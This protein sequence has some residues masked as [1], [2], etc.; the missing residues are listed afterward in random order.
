MLFFEA[1]IEG[2]K[3]ILQNMDQSGDSGDK[4]SN[5]KE[6]E[7]VSRLNSMLPVRGDNGYSLMISGIDQDNL[8]GIV[9]ISDIRKPVREV[10]EALQTFLQSKSSQTVRV[11]LEEITADRYSKLL[12]EGYEDDMISRNMKKQDREMR[13]D[14]FDNCMFSV[15][16]EILPSGKFVRAEALK[17]AKNLMADETLLDEIGRI[18]D[19]RNKKRFYGHPVHYLVRCTDVEPGMQMARILVQAL[20]QNKRLSGCR[21]EKIS[22]IEVNCYDENDFESVIRNAVGETVLIE[23]S[24]D[25]DS[26]SNYAS[27]YDR[28]TR[29]IAKLT[30]ERAKDVLFIFLQNKERPG[31]TRSMLSAAEDYMDIVTIEEGTGDRPKAEAYLQSLLF[32]SEMKEFAEKSDEFLDDKKTVYSAKDVR[33]AFNTFESNCLKNNVYPAYL[34]MKKASFKVS[35]SDDGSALSRLDKLVGLSD[36]KRL[37]KEIIAANVIEKKRMDVISKYHKNAMHMVFTGNPGS[38]KTTVARLIADV[39]KEEKVLE[40]GEFVECGRADLVA[41][42]VGWTAKTVHDKFREANGG[43]LFIDEAYSLVDDS[44]TFGAEA[45]NTIVQEMENYRDNVLVIFAGY[46]DKMEKF[47]DEN[48]GLRSRISFHIDFP[49]YSVE[50][51]KQ[52][53]LLMAKDR[54]YTVEDDALKAAGKLFADAVQIEDFGNGRY[55]RNVLEQSIMNQSFRLYTE[56]SGKEIPKEELFILKKEDIKARNI[57]KDLKNNNIIGFSAA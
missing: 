22:Q 16:E 3:G 19:D 24:G 30:E 35:S 18:Y 32:N 28:V 9:A 26:H 36:V 33:R 13:L 53:F 47:L 10:A 6:V 34:G 1:D 51:L 31:F 7:A 52:I 38:A 57:E 29:Y 49:D 5:Q 20:H 14:Y 50:E 41:R 43:V 23:M 17:Q 37:A 27:E 46:P 8:T 48:E 54:G 42:Y 40:T 4:S 55:A 56:Y 39:L 15:K 21:L 45:I 2:A 11:K 25:E 12:D 44:N